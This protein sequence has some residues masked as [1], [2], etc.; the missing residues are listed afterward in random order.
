MNASGRAGCRPAR[1]PHDLGE[2]AAQAAQA[3]GPGDE[4]RQRD[5]AQ[6][7]RVFRGGGA[8]PLHEVT[9][10][11]MYALL[12]AHH[13]EYSVE[14][15]C[16]VLQIA[17]S[18]YYRHLQQQADGARRSARGAAR[19]LAERRHAAGVHTA[20]RGLRR[21]EKPKP[22]AARGRHGGAVYRRVTH[23]QHRDS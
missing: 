4:A 11:T 18:G 5:F 12:D 21:A 23:A 20:P 10:A 9:L 8:R 13:A 6:G 14:P 16:T 22:A 7:Q 2:G 19:C 17:P 3:R 1:W 15:I